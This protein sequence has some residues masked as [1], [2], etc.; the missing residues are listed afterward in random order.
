MA[1]EPELT[2]EEQEKR[3]QAIPKVFP[4][5]PFMSWLGVEFDTYEHDEVVLTRSGYRS[6]GSPEAVEDWFVSAGFTPPS[7]AITD[8]GGA[9]ARG[10]EACRG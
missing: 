5:T 1:D 9:S 8:D 10:C 2:E 4:A 3:R 6:L 7:F